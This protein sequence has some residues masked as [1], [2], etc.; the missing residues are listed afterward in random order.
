MHPGR[1]HVNRNLPGSAIQC[2]VVAPI[3]FEQSDGR[4]VD[5][6][7]ACRSVPVTQEYQMVCASLLHVQRICLLKSVA[8]CVMEDQAEHRVFIQIPGSAWKTRQGISVE[9]YQA[10]CVCVCVW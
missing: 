7:S 5:R 9:C 4:V 8:D 1:Q 10:L 6:R 2:L 3:T